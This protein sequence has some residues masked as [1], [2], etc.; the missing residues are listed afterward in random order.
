MFENVDRRT[1]A[2]V[3]GILLAHPWAFRSVEPITTQNN[4]AFLILK[5]NIIIFQNVI[6]G[7][8]AKSVRCLTIDTCL[9]AD[10]W[11]VRLIPV[12]FFRGD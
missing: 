12:P 3:T 11:V 10:P 6:T 9:T 7:P 1:D 4:K 5:G 8:L 2:G